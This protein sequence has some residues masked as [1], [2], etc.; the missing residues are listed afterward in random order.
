MQKY[1]S[2]WVAPVL[3]ALFVSPLVFVG[4][5]SLDLRPERNQAQA[6]AVVEELG[7]LV[8]YDYQRPDPKLPNHF[9]PDAVPKTP[10]HVVFV[11]LGD[12]S[13][14]NEDL[15]FLR[16]FPRL[17]NLILSNTS[18]TGGGL[19]HLQGLKNLKALSLWNT[20]V[21]DAGLRYIESHKKLWLLILD[22]TN[23]TDAGLVYLEG[24][25]NLEEWL[26]LTNTQI[27]D[28]GLR[29]LEGL[30]KLRSLNLRKTKVT[31]AGAAELKRALS[32]TMISHGS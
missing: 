8:Q 29:H 11:D 27:T 25:T 9:D 12:T 13:I 1:K 10:G 4:C 17:E 31:A 5:A 3:F 7:G 18:I 20:P 2:R 21:D 19:A 30:V 32:N 15:K 16:S 28:D 14:T 24:L 26:G 22:G 6:V 23:I